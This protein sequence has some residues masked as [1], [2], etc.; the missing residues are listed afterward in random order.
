MYYNNFVV[1]LAPIAIID[2][3]EKKSFQFQ[4]KQFDMIQIKN[5]YLVDRLSE[6]NKEEIIEIKNHHN[7]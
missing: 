1:V 3:N 2:Q 7:F 6:N 5:I 4:I